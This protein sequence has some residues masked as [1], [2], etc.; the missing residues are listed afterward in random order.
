MYEIWRD[1]MLDQDVETDPW[2]ELDVE[3]HNAWMQLA[4]VIGEAA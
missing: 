4:M 2:E 3:A 1:A